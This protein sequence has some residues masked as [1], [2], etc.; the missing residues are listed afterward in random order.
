MTNFPDSA[1][2][3]IFN[4][5]P[6]PMAV[7]KPQGPDY[8]ILD[9]NKVFVN[10]SK[11]TKE[12]LIDQSIFVVFP[13][14]RDDST[15]ENLDRLRESF[16][17]AIK[18]KSPAVMR[19]YRY[20]V[21]KQNTLEFQE[22][23]WTTTTTPILDDEGTVL[24]LL[25]APENVTELKLANA[26]E[27]AALELLK[28]QQS[29]LFSVFMQ[30][31]VGIGIIKGKNYLVEMINPSLCEVYGQ[32]QNDLLGQPLFDVLKEAR[33]A[34]FEEL[35]DTVISTGKPFKG[36]A[37]EMS[38]MRN[39]NLETVCL[40]FVYEPFEEQDGTITGVI[41]V[42]N[43]VTD[44]ECSKKLLEESQE[45]ANL[46]VD[47]V[48]LGTFD[49][50]LIS[51]QT[52]TSK[53]FANIFGFENPVPRDEYVKTFDPEDLPKR[54]QAMNDAMSTGK[55][56]YEMRVIWKDGSIHWVRIEGKVFHDSRN[57]PIRILGIS[58]DITKQRRA[59]SE[60][61]K[62]ISL[63]DNSAELMSILELNGFNSYINLAGQRMLGFKSNEE[64][65]STPIS[66][67]HAPEDHEFVEREVIPAVMNTGFWT[68]I[69]K[70]RHLQS[71]E[72]F[73]V[74]NSTVRIDDP[75]TGKPIAI[76][77][78]MRD[79]RPEMASKQALADSE[80]LLRKITSAAPTTLWMTD[81]TGKITYVNQTWTD[82]TGIS[83]EESVEFGF[84]NGIHLDDR[85]M[86]S[87]KLKHAFDTH[88]SFDL[89]F[90]L[91]YA[92]GT[93]HWCSLNA[94]PQ[95]KRDGEFS[96]FIGACVDISEQK[97]LQ[98]Q[99]D[100]FIGIASH[101]LKTPVTSIKAY[102]Q[103]LQRIL[104]KNGESKEAIMVGRMDSQINRL[105]SLIGD[106]LDVTKINS[107][108]LNYNA[109]AYNFDKTVE[110]LAEDLQR[111]TDCHKIELDVHE[112][113]WVYGDEERVSQVIL[114]LMTNAIKYSPDADK[115]ILITRIENEIV[116][117]CVEDF[118]IGIEEDKLNRVF[119]QFYRVS[120]GK[121]QS[122][123]GIGLGLY[124]SSEIIRR[125][126]GKIWVNSE[127]GKGAT[128]C[129]ELPIKRP[130]LANGLRGRDKLN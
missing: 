2:V 20:D 54:E 87:I 12:E 91:S 77:A 88:K 21:A 109:K 69:I 28:A 118:G 36:E 86:A 52:F 78:V 103:I 22:S 123:P 48:G 71:K 96:G 15:S 25:Y 121:H 6:A 101:E 110:Y 125:E 119:E 113:G 51:N 89:E 114:N 81:K 115:I 104:S 61:Q 80:H 93:A 5:S 97:L 33:G 13:D 94:H 73:P 63:A 127:I 67:L 40:D 42:A 74:Y 32:S 102:T 83:F 95:H 50:D 3:T 26:R 19:D 120:G 10:A 129:F 62:L 4:E 75:Y 37:Y 46:V 60:Q 112:I 47:S 24:Y 72:V 100:D 106:L 11:F 18:T 53:Q 84:L 16:Q 70:V 49:V 122:F 41:I 1:F 126:G 27:Q 8:I 38:L 108:K 107:G 99:K 59:Q 116:T 66:D 39:G 34:G 92:D 35:L 7:L 57:K 105:N 43:D 44:R 111:T 68:G 55:L 76:G 128:F 31:P 30:A 45:R 9:V 82:W 90:R 23:H 85:K 29:K 64:A 17:E 130:P 58:L 117:F 56:V 65:L 98:Q 124:I 14:R 79:M